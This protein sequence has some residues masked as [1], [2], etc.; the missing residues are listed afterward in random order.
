MA[1]EHP[2]PEG[3]LLLK[4]KLLKSI[5]N[6]VL[7]RLKA[8]EAYIAQTLHDMEERRPRKLWEVYCGHGRTSEI[9]TSF[10]METQRFGFETGTF[11]CDLINELSWTCSMR[12]YQ[13]KFYLHHPVRLGLPCRTPTCRM[14]A[15]AS[16]CNNFENGITEFTCGFAGGFT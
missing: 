5:N 3:S 10:G 1:D 4:G 8:A 16:S 12:N 7:T 15:N 11:H 2:A 13:M 14:S 9:A 6:F